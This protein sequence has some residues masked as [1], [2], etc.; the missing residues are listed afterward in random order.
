MKTLTLQPEGCSFT[1]KG[2][3]YTLSN[4]SQNIFTNTWSFDL[5][6]KDGLIRGVPITTGTSVIKGNGTPFPKLIFLDF[7]SKDGDVT[8]PA[9][10]KM[11]ILE[12]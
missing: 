3:R 4:F 2:A 10:V 8:V 1:Y 6:W 9:N 5:Q 7:K 12:G 11:L